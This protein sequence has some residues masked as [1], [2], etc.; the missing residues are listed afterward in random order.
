MTQQYSPV[1]PPS[2]GYHPDLL[3]ALVW[4]FS[5]HWTSVE[6]LPCSQGA[7]LQLEQSGEPGP[8]APYLLEACTASFQ[9]AQLIFYPTDD[10]LPFKL[11]FHWED[12]RSCNTKSVRQN[13]TCTESGVDFK[14][15]VDCVPSPCTVI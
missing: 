8:W 1:G 5:C 4:D 2:P 13:P 12:G 3:I 11:L 10:T 14:P 7:Q 15:E 6:R 9:T